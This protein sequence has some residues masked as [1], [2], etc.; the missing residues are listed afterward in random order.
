MLPLVDRI[1]CILVF[2]S[3][4]ARKQIKGKQTLWVAPPL[5]TWQL[6]VGL[7]QLGWVEFV[8]LKIQ[9]GYQIQWSWKFCFSFKQVSRS[10]SRKPESLQ[11][12]EFIWGVLGQWRLWVVLTLVGLLYLTCDV[13]RVKFWLPDLRRLITYMWACTFYDQV[14]P[15]FWFHKQ[16]KTVHGIFYY[17]YWTICLVNEIEL[18]MLIQLLICNLVC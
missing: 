6:P 8:L 7:S 14:I 4:V 15:V 13:L 11:Q 9:L 1:C 12:C 2:I 18:H 3:I 17:Q 5:M 10:A 16:R